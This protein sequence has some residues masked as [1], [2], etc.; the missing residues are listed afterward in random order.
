L[1]SRAVISGRE[2]PPGH[3]EI[4]DDLPLPDGQGKGGIREK[5]VGRVKEP[6]TGL[7]LIVAPGT[8][9]FP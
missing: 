1:K 8:M 3:I 2:P 4:F 7:K 5:K 9:I 6:G